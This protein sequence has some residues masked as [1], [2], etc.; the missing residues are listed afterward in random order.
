MKRN[1]LF[2][3]LMAVLFPLT[4]NADEIMVGTATGDKNVAPFVNS[5]PNSWLEMVYTAEEI[6][7]ACT[8]ANISFQHVMGTSFATNDLRIYLAE[9]TKSVLA[10]KS[11]WTPE[12][13]LTLVYSGTNVVIGDEEWESFELDTPFEYSGEKNLAVVVAK[14]AGGMNMTLTWACYDAANSVMFTASDT[15]P[16]FAQYPAANALAMYGKKP[17]M[18]LSDGKE[19]EGGEEEGEE[20][21]EDDNEEE[22]EPATLAA[23]TNLRATIRQDVE[24]FGYKFEITMAWDA[25]EGATGYDVFV[26]TA[27]AQDFH[28]GY[29]N[30]TAYVAGTDKE[31][32]LEFY[33]IAFNDETESAPSEPYT[34]TIVDDAVEEM[35]ASFNVYPNPVNDRLYIET[36]AEVKEVVVYDVYGRRQQT[37]DNGQ[38]TLSID[39]ANLS[40]GVYFVKVV[41]EN[42]E[43]VKRFV[44]E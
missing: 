2:L 5:Y 20:G 7:Q 1:L 32:T 29:T 36:E 6:G 43:V 38:Q 42:G 19:S 24:G 3:M 25:V 16:S 23:P 10:N 22:I 18:K 40:N 17:V 11:D 15:D 34:I 4:M 31:G 44:K 35:T 14:T 26:N 39:V 21:D 27:T 33:V 41:T 9:T 28:M 8:I 37:T 12:S 13:E 30:G